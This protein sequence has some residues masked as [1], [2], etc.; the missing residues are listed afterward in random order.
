MFDV[1]V[2]LYEN[3]GALQ[4]CPDAAS[5]SRSLSEAGFEDD[6]IREA[7]QWLQELARTTLDDRRIVG[8]AGEGLRLYVATEIAHL[9]RGGID[10]L[11]GLE[12]AGQLDEARREVVIERALAL[13]E[14]PIPRATLRVIVLMVLWSLSA[15]VDLLLLE[16]LLGGDEPRM[17]H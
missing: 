5:L 17:L 15:D 10:F 13:G 3:Y 7:L 4:T 16:D 14:T 2:Y 6:E 12:R 11:V 8:T 1:L 9:G